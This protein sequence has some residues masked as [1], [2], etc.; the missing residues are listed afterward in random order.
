MRVESKFCVDAAAGFRFETVQWIAGIAW[1]V[2]NNGG[3][4][5]LIETAGSSS[6]VRYVSAIRPQYRKLL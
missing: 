3:E 2:T 6:L 5:Q 4:M 1:I